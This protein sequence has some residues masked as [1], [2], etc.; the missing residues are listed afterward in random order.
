MLVPQV[1]F[2]D[3]LPDFN[4]GDRIVNHPECERLLVDQRISDRHFI[5]ELHAILSAFLQRKALHDAHGGAAHETTALMLRQQMRGLH[6]QLR[7]FPVAPGI[8]GV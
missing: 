7:A 5:D 4:A 1:L 3:V 6:D 8:A 2:A